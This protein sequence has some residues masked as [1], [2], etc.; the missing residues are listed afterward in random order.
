MRGLTY[1]YGKIPISLSSVHNTCK[2]S[3]LDTC[4]GLRVFPPVTWFAPG[5]TNPRKRSARSYK[6]TKGALVKEFQ[7][8][9]FPEP[10]LAA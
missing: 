1:M 4:L 7:D 10:Q 2:Q 3:L 5:K 8:L 9:G 6:R